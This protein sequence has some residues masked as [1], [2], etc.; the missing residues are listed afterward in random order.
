MGLIANPTTITPSF[1][2]AADLLHGHPDFNLVRLFGPEHGIR[3]DAQYMVDVGHAIDPH[4][5]LPTVS[6][7]GKT[8]ETLTPQ[9]EDIHDLD[10]L[11]FDIQDVGTRYYTYAATMALAMQAAQG[12]GI[13]FVV[14][15]RPNPINGVS[16]EG[17][18]LLPHLV[19]FCGL[20]PIPQRHGMTVG[21]LARLYNTCFNIGCD[22]HVI[23]CQGWKRHTFYP[24]TGLPWVFPSPNMPT[25]ET[26]L[27]YPGLCLLEATN[28]SEGRGT[29]KPFEIFGAPFINAYALKEHLQ[30]YDLPGIAFRT[31]SFTPTFD[32]YT[33]QQCHGLQIHIL[34]PNSIKPYATGLAIL[35][36]L[37]SMYPETFQWRQTPYEFR[38]DV[39]A[40][41]L[42]TGSPTV[43]TALDAH[44]G[45]DAILALAYTGTE[46]YHTHRAAS[47][48][49]YA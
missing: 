8:F 33:H 6:L 11:V 34:N 43:R 37:L 21:E 44:S 18:G 10:V 7:Y 22:L 14:L 45:F 32:K 38:D 1:E 13:P 9:P 19:N 15:D 16:V 31:C 20:Y 27:L 12:N 4:T 35:H 17:G 46:L 40:I 2:H 42:L 26:A 3:G 24:E 47:L 28:I 48:L 39:P 30:S 29:T 36:A 25:F 23:P 49:D 41:D 5:G